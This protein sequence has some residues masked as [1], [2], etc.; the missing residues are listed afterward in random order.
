MG[1]SDKLAENLFVMQNT[2][3]LSLYLLACLQ[4]EELA[5]PLDRQTY[6]NRPK[7]YLQNNKMSALRS[8]FREFLF[9]TPHF[10]SAM[11]ETQ[12]DV[13]C[14]R[15][16]MDMVTRKGRW[17]LTNGYDQTPEHHKQ[18]PPPPPTREGELLKNWLLYHLKG[19]LKIQ[20]YI[21]SW[22][23]TLSLNICM[24]NYKKEREQHSF[25]GLR[26]LQCLMQAC[27]PHLK[28]DVISNICLL[29]PNT[30]IHNPLGRH[31][32]FL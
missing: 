26:A 16:H 18:P 28:H 3:F 30:H 23:S 13:P 20:N 12:T 10:T 4:Q 14:S 24:L 31:T 15:S 8:I 32:G 25:G 11:P 6:Q 17:L 9:Q 2:R 19:A 21:G 7:H 1:R 29:A 22:L 27:S 5:Q